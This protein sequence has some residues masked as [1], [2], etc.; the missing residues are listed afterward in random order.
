MTRRKLFAWL[1]GAIAAP[2]V[3]VIAKPVYVSETIR[4]AA[5]A[6]MA[7]EAYRKAKAEAE[8]EVKSRSSQA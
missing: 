1:S 3:P 8:A 6:A 2:V 7:L 5:D 4:A